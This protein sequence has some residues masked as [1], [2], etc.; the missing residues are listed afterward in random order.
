MQRFR[1]VNRPSY[2]Q[3]ATTIQCIWRAYKA[4]KRFCKVKDAVNKIQ[5]C[6]RGWLVRKRLREQAHSQMMRTRFEAVMMRHHDRLKALQ[7]ERHE[8]DQLNPSEMS[9]R[10]VKRTRAAIVIQA[11]WRGLLARRQFQQDASVARVKA[12]AEVQRQRQR[13]RDEARRASLRHS[14]L[15]SA[16]LSSSVASLEEMHMGMAGDDAAVRDAGRGV[17]TNGGRRRSD[18]KGGNSVRNNN[19][20][21]DNKGDTAGK[22]PFGRAVRNSTTHPSPQ[23]QA[24]KSGVTWLDDDGQEQ[25]VD[26][27][28]TSASHSGFSG[29]DLNRQS[30]LQIPKPSHVVSGLGELEDADVLCGSPKASTTWIRSDPIQSSSPLPP[31]PPLPLPSIA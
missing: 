10:H 3:A 19:S 29:G 15:F 2:D 6:L 7:S 4:R 21:N 12:A 23:S 1:R 9:R 8:L 27:S 26:A 30:S 28:S 11:F 20:S 5:A 31:P 14:A 13:R 17:V 18:Y 16:V 24:P 25:G 22:D